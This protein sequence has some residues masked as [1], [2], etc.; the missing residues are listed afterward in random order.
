VKIPI[1]MYH[2]IDYPPKRGAVMRGLVVSPQSF[3]LQMALLKI[4]G[5]RGLSMSELD[6]YLRGEKKGKVV[7][8]TFDDGYQNNLTHALPVLLN[9]GFSA[10]CYAV[11]QALG[12]TNAWDTSVGIISKP[13]MTVDEWKIWQKKG[14]EIG[15]HTRNHV[16][17]RD[18]SDHMAVMEIQQSRLDLEKQFGG[19][20][21]HFC[22]PY[23]WFAPK[24]RQM[25]VDAGYKTATTTMRGRAMPGDDLF[26][27]KRIKVA[28]ATT[29]VMFAAKML[30]RY[31]DKR[32]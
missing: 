15:S 14:M 28:R 22:Y 11:S 30:S 10:T 21:R 2:Q 13:L 25:V 27:L 24:H 18:C 9:N 23:G 16:N 5:Y 32:A 6:P 17:L 1:L 12:G 19:Q 31:E 7:G 4:L 3:T 29:L 8:L 26:A 20:V